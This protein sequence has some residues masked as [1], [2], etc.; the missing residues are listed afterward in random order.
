M[1]NKL[2]TYLCAGMGLISIFLTAQHFSFNPFT[3]IQSIKQTFT[4]EERGLWVTSK[5]VSSAQ[6]KLILQRDLPSRGYQPIQ[7][8]IQNNTPKSYRLN[9]D[10]LTGLRIPSQT[11]ANDVFKEALPRSI[12]LK[13]A[14]FFF[15]PLAIPSAID[16][17]HTMHTYSSLK[18]DYLAKELRNE[19]IPPY[20]TV[21]RILFVKASPNQP[22][23]PIQLID[24]KSGETLT[25]RTQNS[26]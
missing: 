24:T 13:I 6:S 16:G 11:L 23:Y 25:Y 9:V 8:S 21:N 4:K 22:T 19:V 7:I 5:A 26:T 1:K 18:S 2:F 14:S 20:A 12:G 15:W 17:I 3:P 10:N